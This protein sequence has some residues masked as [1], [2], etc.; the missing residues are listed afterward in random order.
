MRDRLVKYATEME[1]GHLIVL[2]QFGSMP[3]A[4][5]RKNMELFARIMPDLQSLSPLTLTLSPAAGEGT[6]WAPSPS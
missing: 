6:K 1:V 5:A 3:D 2:L 4:M